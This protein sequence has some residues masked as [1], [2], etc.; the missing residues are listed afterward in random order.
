MAVAG[1]AHLR[2]VNGGHLGD[3][4]WVT[5]IATCDCG[6]EQRIRLESEGAVKWQ[7]GALVQNALPHLSINE[8]EALI[9]GTCQ[10]CWD[11][12]TTFAE[13]DENE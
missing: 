10:R 5:L 12:M 8:R 1:K 11:L 3:Q 7:R 9:S 6:H 4:E 2:I 13:E